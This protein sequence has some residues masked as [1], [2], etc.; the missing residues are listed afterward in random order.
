M[1]YF[2]HTVKWPSGALQTSLHK[3]E[4]SYTN[5]SLV[6]RR[7]ELL[8]GAVQGL[9][10]LPHL[11]QGVLDFT[12]LIQDLHAAGEGV[13]ADCEGAL[14]VCRVFPVHIQQIEDKY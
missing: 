8:Q 4:K 12:G 3:E 5:V 1:V 6:L 10:V 7:A 11:A 9:E 13:I 2:I 14:D